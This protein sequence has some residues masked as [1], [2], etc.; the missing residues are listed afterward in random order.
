MF[1]L[2][3]YGLFILLGLWLDQT[4]Q[5][6]RQ[7][8]IAIFVLFAATFCFLETLAVQLLKLIWYIV[9]F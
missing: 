7:G 9:A 8:V 6:F 2:I 5:T 3:G 1:E 4:A